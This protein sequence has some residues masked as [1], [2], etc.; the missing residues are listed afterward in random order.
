[1][2]VMVAV[3]TRGDTAYPAHPARQLMPGIVRELAAGKLLIASRDLPDG[4]FS[5]TVILLADYG[6]EGAMGLI[7]NRQSDIP[8]S[9]AFPKLKAVSPGARIFVGGPVGTTKVVGLLRARNPEKNVRH[10][11][12]DIFLVAERE[13]L[14]GLIGSDT[15]SRHFRVYFGY[16]GWASG[17]LEHE[18]VEGAWHV[19]SADPD[20]V[21]DPDPATIWQREIRR[22]EGLMARR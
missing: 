18:A 7:L 6:A 11:V 12:S 3:R 19:V 22:T 5:E 10:I 13:P 1:M 4:N 8:V 20:L 9:K 14:E 17:Q 15:D 16:A 21:F 2:V